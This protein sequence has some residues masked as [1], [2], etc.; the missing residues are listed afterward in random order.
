MDKAGRVRSSR[1]MCVPTD[2]VVIDPLPPYPLLVPPL[3]R[4]GSPSLGRIVISSYER[5]L[6]LQVGLIQTSTN[7]CAAVCNFLVAVVMDFKT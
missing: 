7:A 2:R 4:T 5:R 3:P 1:G 6:V